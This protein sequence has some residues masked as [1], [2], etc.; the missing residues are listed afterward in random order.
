MERAAVGTPGTGGEGEG[1]RV[2]LVVGR[3]VGCAEG[4]ALALAEG[5]SDDAAVG[6]DEGLALGSSV[7]P[8]DGCA[9]GAALGLGD[10]LAVGSLVGLIVLAAVEDEALRLAVGTALGLVEG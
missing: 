3:N 4:D 8:A 9:A 2:A 1:A 7:R 10:G 5:S 6:L